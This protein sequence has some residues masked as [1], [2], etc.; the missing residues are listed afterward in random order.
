MTVWEGGR[1]KITTFLRPGA[2]Q[3]GIYYQRMPGQLSPTCS[4]LLKLPNGELLVAVD[5]NQLRTMSSETVDLI[6]LSHPPLSWAVP[7]EAPL[8]ALCKCGL[9]I[10]RL[11][12]ATGARTRVQGYARPTHCLCG[13]SGYIFYF[14]SFHILSFCFLIYLSLSYF[15]FAKLLSLSSLFL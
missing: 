1:T 15:I 8:I 10:A 5:H 13:H 14:T 4:N 6:D 7:P 3:W 2:S 12:A 11:A 9:Q